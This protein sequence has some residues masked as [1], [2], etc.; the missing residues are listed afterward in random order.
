MPI[1]FT[2]IK[3]SSFAFVIIE[4]PQAILTNRALKVLWIHAAGWAFDLQPRLADNF[5]KF[6]LTR[7]HEMRNTKWI[8]ILG[9]SALALSGGISR[10][11]TDT[12]TGENKTDVNGSMTMGDNKSRSKGAGT[13]MSGSSGSTTTMRRSSSS[14]SMSGNGMGSA[15]GSMSSGMSGSETTTYRRRRTVI[16]TTRPGMMRSSSTRRYRT[17]RSGTYRTGGYRTSGYRTGGYSYRRTSRSMRRMHSGRM[18]HMSSGHHRS[19]AR[20]YAVTGE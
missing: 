4:F 2:A 8:A 13:G 9:I 20:S 17:Y 14:S 6:R 7:K 5:V 12:T 11:Q 1:R 16:T 19:M 10:A 18:M 15:D 3:E